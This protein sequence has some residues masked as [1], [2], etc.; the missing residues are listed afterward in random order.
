MWRTAACLPPATQQVIIFVLGAL[1][2][3][4]YAL[5]ARCV[6]GVLCVCINAIFTR[7]QYDSILH[8]L[9][10]AACRLPARAMWRCGDGVWGMA[11]RDDSTRMNEEKKKVTTIVMVVVFAC[12][13]A[14][15]ISMLT[16]RHTRPS[17]V[18]TCRLYSIVC[19]TQHLPFLYLLWLYPSGYTGAA[20]ATA[21]CT[22]PEDDSGVSTRVERTKAH[23]VRRALA[24]SDEPTSVESNC[25]ENKFWPSEV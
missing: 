19:N 6:L 13:L 10:P 8:R 24:T 16:C 4:L 18:P 21:V 14:K 20:A 23:M 1:T 3:W 22:Y 9:L 7:I 11:P 15:T 17:F 2:P 5:R 12:L 25:W